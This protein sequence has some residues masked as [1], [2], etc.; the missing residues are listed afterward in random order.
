VSSEEVMEVAKE[1]EVKATPNPTNNNFNVYVRSN[2]L[3]DKIIMKVVDMYGRIIEVRNVAAGQIIKLGDKYRAV[4]FFVKF[5][6]GEDHKQLKL[7][8]L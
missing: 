7:V 3:K 8:K 5:I 4:T 2:N 1:L 6:Q